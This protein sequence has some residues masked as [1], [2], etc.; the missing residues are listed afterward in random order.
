MDPFDIAPY[1]GI[2]PFEHHWF[3]KNGLR[4]HYLDEGEGRPI[5]MLHGNPTWS[6]MYRELVK[7][8]RSDHR[9][10]VPDHMGMGL[11]DRPDDRKYDHRLASRIDDVESLL[12]HLGIE[13]DITLI[14]HDWG[15]V[16][17]AG[18]AE[19]RPEA[20]SRFIFM[21]TAAFRMPSKKRL[22]LS[23]FYVK[24]GLISPT[25]MIRGFNAFSGIA[26]RVGVKRKLDPLVRKGYVAPY[27]SWRNR[28]ATLR[29]VQDIPLSPKDPSYPILKGIEENLPRLKGKPML[30]IWGEKD[31]IF[32]LDI[33]RIWRERFPEAT[34]LT[35]PRAGHYVIE[36]AQSE[37]IE[38][39]KKDLRRE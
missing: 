34:F 23:L 10:I 3:K 18:V 13:R 20:F 1:K 28:L 25:V 33:L 39:I 12:D 5:L 8:L 22:P 17:G 29:F 4:Y 27:N 35:F 21:N 26:S 37:I 7:E 32:D 11:S 14:A 6:F 19:R 31:F 38:T 16:I 36:D 15:G 24:Y 2:Y 30:V 9:C